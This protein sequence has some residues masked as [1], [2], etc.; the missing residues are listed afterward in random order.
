M[1]SNMFKAYN[2]VPRIKFCYK[3]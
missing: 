2:C 1:K 3:Q